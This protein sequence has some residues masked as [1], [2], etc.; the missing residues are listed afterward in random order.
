MIEIDVRGDLAGIF[1]LPHKRKTRRSGGVI[2]S[3][4]DCGAGFALN[5][6]LKQMN[7]GMLALLAADER[8]G[9]FRTPA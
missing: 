8:C 7:R 5:L 6:W 1:T 3:K 2:A 9:L 4:D